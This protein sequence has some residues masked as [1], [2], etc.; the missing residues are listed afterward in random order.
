MFGISRSFYLQVRYSE[1]GAPK[2]GSNS[3]YCSL[4]GG[5]NFIAQTSIFTP[6]ALT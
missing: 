2:W 6:M 3:K 1:F 4:L 5:A